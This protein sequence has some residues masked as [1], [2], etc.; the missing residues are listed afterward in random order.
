MVFC[1]KL[2]VFLEQAPDLQRP[3]PGYSTSWRRMK[4]QGSGF[5][6][7][8]FGTIQ[9]C[10]HVQRGEKCYSSP[11]TTWYLYGFFSVFIFNLH[12]LYFYQE[13]QTKTQ[14]TGDCRRWVAAIPRKLNVIQTSKSR[15]KRYTTTVL[16]NFMIIKGCGTPTRFKETCS[17][18]ILLH[19]NGNNLQSTQQILFPCSLPSVCLLSKWRPGLKKMTYTFEKWPSQHVKRGVVISTSEI[20]HPEL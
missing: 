15:H 10:D 20:L 3:W 6:F 17:C 7:F 9:L 12:T 18:L 11:Q 8:F 16:E 2:G 19:I 5:F 13:N 14:E 1:N 4:E